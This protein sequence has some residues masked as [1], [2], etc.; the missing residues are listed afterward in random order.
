MEAT[1]KLVDFILDVDY[2]DITEEATEVAKQCF[3]DCIGVSLAG[4]VLPISEIL[5][6]YVR[7]IGGRSRCSIIGSDVKTSPVNAALVNGTLGHAL[8]YDDM[9][10]PLI[11]HPTVPVLPAVLAVGEFIGASGKQAITAFSLGFEALCKIG[12]AVSPSHWYK[13]FHSTATVGTFG[14][15]AAASKLLNLNEEQMLNAFGIA[16][17]QAAGLKQNFGT[18]TKPFHAGHAA[19]S[20][21][22]AALLAKNGFT[23]AKNI[24]EGQFG[25]AKLMADRY[26]FSVIDKLGNPWDLVD[27]A[28]FFKPY[29]SCGGTHAAMNAMLSLI[30]EYDIRHDEVESLEAGM[31]PIAPE[32]LIYIEPKTAFEGK[33]SMQFCLAIL[34]LEREAGLA[35]FTN[36][37]VRN[38]RTMELMKRIKLYV[39]P[40]IT[41]SVP[42]EWGDKSA[43]VKVKLKDGRYYTR[44]RDIRHL[45]WDELIS[46]Y[47][48]CAKVVL[49]RD[50]ITKS[51]EVVMNLQKLENIRQLM[52][53]T[54]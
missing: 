10:F 50:K 8:D 45:T 37:K 14:A 20:G 52:E 38:P 49:P 53:L 9:I 24:L 31:N 23:A 12:A 27:P 16:G 25:F 4:S 30:E 51:I 44:K 13:G 21:V 1:Q 15:V 7:V 17:S 2:E 40:E 41:A 33:F 3:L 36:E 35:Q 42:P 5:M 39:D 47:K 32:E 46:K 29:P 48:D 19:E 28:P 54:Y 18:M 11:G 26:D 6:S 22:K 34:L 43:V